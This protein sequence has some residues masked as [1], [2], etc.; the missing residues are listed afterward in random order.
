[1]FKFPLIRNRIAHGKLIDNP[2]SLAD[3]LIHDLYNVCTL[4]TRTDLPVNRTVQLIK[5]ANEK[6]DFIGLLRYALYKDVS[7]PDFYNLEEE[8]KVV[9]Q[10]L[11]E[12]EFF[13]FIASIVEHNNPI[14]NAGLTKIIK[15]FKSS[16]INDRLYVDLL[17]KIE[18]TDQTSFS[19]DEFLEELNSLDF[20]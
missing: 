16:G 2:A 7:I 9:N 5:L 11:Y 19:K 20:K 3:Y 12:I 13:E 15:S 8:I 18:S 1:M 6:S 10:K 4:I 17:K 14:L